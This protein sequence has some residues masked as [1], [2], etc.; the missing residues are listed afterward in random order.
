LDPLLTR[1][2]VI[3]DDDSVRVSLRRLLQAAGYECV[4]FESGTEFLHSLQKDAHV[5]DTACCAIVDVRMPGID[6]IELTRHLQCAHPQLRVVLIT[7][8]SDEHTKAA[9][10]ALGVVLLSKPF[11]DV[12]LFEAL[13]APAAPA[14]PRAGAPG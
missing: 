13:A 6:G 7:A 8:S 5:C 11:D 4:T 9:S 3:D 12:K 2:F 14:A 10:A 1:I